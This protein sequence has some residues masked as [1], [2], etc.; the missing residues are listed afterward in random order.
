[1]ALDSAGRNML[2]TLKEVCREEDARDTVYGKV[3]GVTEGI[4]TRHVLGAR[5]SY[6]FPTRPVY[7]SLVV[8]GTSSRWLLSRGL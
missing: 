2:L 3:T 8:L 4:N 1:M 7:I 6:C 5:C